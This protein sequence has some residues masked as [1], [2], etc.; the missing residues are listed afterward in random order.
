MAALMLFAV[1]AFAQTA[2]SPMVLKD[3]PTDADGR[4][5]IG[6]LFDN[7]GAYGDVQ[8]GTRTG[9]TTLLDAAAVQSIAGR[10]GAYWDNP[11]GLH[12]IMVASGADGVPSNTAAAPAPTAGNQQ[13][14]VFTH[15]MNTG[16]IVQAE[17]LQFAA[18]A[19]L[20]SGMPQDARAVVGKVVRYPL[21]QGAAVRLSDLTS[22]IVVKRSEAVEV[23]WASNGLSLSMTGTAQKDAAVGDLIQ[24]QNP[25]SKKLIDAVITGPGQA[26]AGPAAEQMRSGMLLSSR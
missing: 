16:D 21:R 26:L 19:A 22:P 11:K 6:D 4:I 25:V 24:V 7:A 5:T 12:R 3:S 8:L 2:A 23:T 18:V 1:P 20:S 10:A 9:A 17:D 13:A 14:L 15:P